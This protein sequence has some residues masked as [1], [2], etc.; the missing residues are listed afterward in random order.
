MPKRW[1]SSSGLWAVSRAAVEDTS[2]PQ[3]PPLSNGPVSFQDGFLINGGGGGG[4]SETVSLPNAP[5]NPASSCSIIIGDGN[6]ILGITG[7]APYQE[8]TIINARPSVYSAFFT[9]SYAGVSQ[10]GA[11]IT[12]GRIWKVI[13][14]PAP[15]TEVFVLGTFV[16]DPTGNTN[17]KCVFKYDT[18][19]FTYTQLGIGVQ[20]Q[21][22]SPAQFWYGGCDGYWDEPTQRLYITGMFQNAG[23][24]A[25]TAGVAYWNETTLTWNAMGSGLVSLIRGGTSMSPK[26]DP[27]GNLLGLYV[28]GEFSSASGVAGTLRVAF[29]DIATSTWSPLGSGVGTNASSGQEV[30]RMYYSSTLD[31][32]YL[33]GSFT[34][35]TPSSTG[36]IG[37]CTYF[38]YWDFVAGNYNPVSAPAGVNFNGNCNDFYVDESTQN[39]YLAGHFTQ[40]RTSNVATNGLAKWTQSL[41][42]W[43]LWGAGFSTQPTIGISGQNGM[44]IFKTSTNKLFLFHTGVSQPTDENGKHFNA[45]NTRQYNNM[46]VWDLTTPTDWDIIANGYS[47]S[48]VG[49]IETAP[50]E[51]VLCG[52]GASEVGFTPITYGSPGAYNFKPNNATAIVFDKIGQEGDEFMPV[53]GSPS[54]SVRCYLTVVNQIVRLIYDPMNNCWRTMKGLNQ[55][56]LLSDA[57][58][59]YWSP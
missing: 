37:D 36:T 55:G 35:A 3:P 59:S 10:A 19:T 39:I 56:G 15:S 50:N 13:P 6:H 2:G 5:L 47:N 20:P 17:G 11:F 29:W 49:C 1:R 25:N 42:S 30:R 31:R 32:L 9:H 54:F 41:G 4:G 12:S 44:K 22:A 51:Y 52:S 8:K 38:C 26:L 21:T 28:A 57:F 46:A 40:T 16:K 27:V 45:M 53:A 7:V 34:Q 24:V 58:S 48:V 43:N 33:S 23:G 14:K 18:A